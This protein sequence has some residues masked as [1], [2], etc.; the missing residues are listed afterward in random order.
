MLY[1]RLYCMSWLSYRSDA[2]TFPTPRHVITVCGSSETI[3]IL[4]RSHSQGQ[5]GQHAHGQ[6]AYSHCQG[7]EKIGDWS[8]MLVSAAGNRSWLSEPEAQR[9][10][11]PRVAA[12]AAPV[13]A[14]SFAQAPLPLGY[15]DNGGGG[16]NG[17]QVATSVPTPVIGCYP[18]YQP[19]QSQQQQRG[20]GQGQGQSQSQGQGQGQGQQR[21]PALA[22]YFHYQRLRSHS[23]SSFTSETS[24]SE[25]SNNANANGGSYFHQHIGNMGGRVPALPLPMDR[26]LSST[27]SSF[28]SQPVVAALEQAVMYSH[29]HSNHA[30]PPSS[31]QAGSGQA[32]YFTGKG[33]GSQEYELQVEPTSPRLLGQD[34]LDGNIYT[35][36]GQSYEHSGGDHMHRAITH[37]AGHHSHEQQQQQQQHVK[38]PLQLVSNTPIPKLAAPAPTPILPAVVEVIGGNIYRPLPTRAIYTHPPSH[39]YA[40]SPGQQTY[41]PSLLSHHHPMQLQLLPNDHVSTPQSDV[42]STGNTPRSYI[43]D[44]ETTGARR[45]GG[46]ERKEMGQE[47]QRTRDSMSIKDSSMRRIHSSGSFR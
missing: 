28:T 10:W 34:P 13:Q 7:A 47:T 4:K 42:F 3:P 6:H 16:S 8:T 11:N 30:D 36:T 45:V 26:S 15:H 40:T 9:Y 21:V 14:Y 23:V 41:S 22:R 12:A 44:T 37:S 46:G 38:T 17:G 35:T 1:H 29:A 20:Q 19:E 31:S 25:T 39:V 32:L 27:L 33:F 5:S 43:D 2:S 18:G 24:S